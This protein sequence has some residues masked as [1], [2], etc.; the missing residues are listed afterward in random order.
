[1]EV[2]HAWCEAL[3]WME[4]GLPADPEMV[5][6]AHAVVPRMPAAEVAALAT[7]FRSWMGQ[8]AIQAALRRES[9]PTGPDIS[10]RVENE[11][12]FV[13]RVGDE[14]QEG[15]VD[16]LVLV[17]GGG[18][19]V[20][21]HVLDFKTDAI[22]PGDES[23]VEERAEHYRPQIEAYCEVIREQYGLNQDAVRGTLLFLAAGRVV[24]VG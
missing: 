14:I 6:L 7:E 19:V 22:D 12:P 4:G 23:A 21:A 1:G 10:V 9:Y 17:E 16:R 11:R 13:R 8:A 5:E 3:E 2:V 24:E 20:E 15:F 18:Q